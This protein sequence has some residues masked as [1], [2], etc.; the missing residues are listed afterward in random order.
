MSII[1]R[2]P[3]PSDEACS[4]AW[5]QIASIARFHCLIVQASGGVMTLALPGEQRKAGL[6]INVLQMHEMSE[7][8]HDWESY[9]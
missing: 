8:E 5:D 9:R 1:N 4:L 6:R 7:C 2:S 3:A